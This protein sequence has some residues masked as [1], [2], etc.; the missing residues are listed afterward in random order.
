MPL[1]R[2][3]MFAFEVVVVGKEDRSRC[4]PLMPKK[5]EVDH[6][7]RLE[8]HLI[9]SFAYPSNQ[10]WQKRPGSRLMKMSKERLAVLLM[11]LL[12]RLKQEIS[13]SRWYLKAMCLGNSSGSR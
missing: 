13:L 4:L 1:A 2:K 12:R 6:P 9:E 11:V 8:L 3:T 5:K 7:N 10:N